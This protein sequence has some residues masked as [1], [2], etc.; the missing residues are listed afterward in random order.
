M[1]SM[2]QSH[3]VVEVVVVVVVEVVVVE[4]EVS[5]TVEVLTAVSSL[6]MKLAGVTTWTER[7]RHP[8]VTPRQL[9][10]YF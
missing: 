4:V 9:R 7:S 3:V 2:G 8:H 1:L 5:L 6:G 10:Q